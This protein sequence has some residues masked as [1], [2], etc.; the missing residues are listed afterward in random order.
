MRKDHPV[1][2]PL[3]TTVGVTLLY[4]QSEKAQAIDLDNLAR[5]F[6]VPMV[7]EELKPP[8]T[9]LDA[10]QNLK[11]DGD[12]D[13]WVREGLERLRRAHKLPVLMG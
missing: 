6:V 12:W 11:P 2:N 13:E 3:F 9:S 8:A 4:V 7:H 5:R 10:I 1:L